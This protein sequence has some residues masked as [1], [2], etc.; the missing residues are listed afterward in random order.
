MNDM[1]QFVC[2]SDSAVRASTPRDAASLEPG[3]FQAVHHPLRLRRRSLAARGGGQWIEESEI[4]RVLEGPLRPDGYLL[5][6]I[7]G[8][9]GTGKSHL[10]R[11]ARD[12]TRDHANW[13]SRYLPKNRTS[14][15]RVIEIVIESLNS[16]AADA[17]RD[18]LLSAPAQSEGDQELADRLMNELALVISA[19]PTTPPTVS[20]P[21]HAQMA[22]KLRRELPDIL[23]DPVVRRRLTRDEAV[24]PR[25]VGLARR[26]RSE[27]DGLDDDA[28]RITNDDLPFQFE[29]IGEASMGARRLLTQLASNP[30]LTSVAVDLINEA[31]PAAVKRVF[32]SGHVDL[33]EIF[34]EVRK[35]LLASGKE[36]VLFIEDLT[37]LH[38]VEREFLDAI[39]E[40]ARS[41]DGDLCS[42]RVLFAVTEGHFDGLDTVRTRCEDA[43]W[44]D[45]AYSPEGVSQAEAASFLGRYL[46]ACRLDPKQ[47][48]D[49]WTDR[50]SHAWLPNACDSC[51]HQV[52]CHETFGRSE[53]GYGLY[54]YNSVAIDRLV[55]SFSSDRFDPRELVRE[56]VHRFLT[57]AASEIERGN[58]PSDTLVASFNENSDPLNPILQSE[59][60]T[61]RPADYSHIV[62]S[63][64]YWSQDIATVEDSILLAFGLDALGPL[65]V[66]PATPTRNRSKSRSSKTSESGPTS[67]P[68]A[69]ELELASQLR[70]PWSGIYE[71]LNSWAGNQRELS[72]RATNQLKAFVHRSVLQNLDFNALP[73]N[74]GA[75]FDEQKRFD[76]DR[77]LRIAGSVT[78]QRYSQPTVVIEQDADTAAALQGL[79]L[80]AEFPDIDDYPR[81]DVYRRHAATYLDEWT[82]CVVRHL[83]QLSESVITEGITGLLA[84]AIVSGACE[85]SSDPR[86]YLAALF[87]ADWSASGV[88]RSP[89][90]Q[91]VL[92]AARSTHHRLRPLLEAHLGEA[93]GTGDVRAV[94]ADQILVHIDKLTKSWRLESTNSAT[95][96]FLRS[97]KPAV[98]E[99]W[100]SMAHLA[101]KSVPYV[102][103]DQ[104]WRQ[105]TERI[106]E[107]VET[108][109][110][111]GRLD[112]HDVARELKTLGSAI[113]E[114]AH[115]RVVR[116]AELVATDP[117]FIVRLQA[118]ASDLPDIVK[119]TGTFVLK[120]E[121]A[122]S[123][124]A[125]DLAARR[126]GAL[127]DETLE[128]VS[129]AVL[130][131]TDRL[132]EAVEELQQ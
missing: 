18:A 70:S 21:K 8:G 1:R 68:S 66:A 25:L 15:R 3:H 87:S 24:V 108:A 110:R 130:A 60:R 127:G 121:R 125:K 91:A 101:T 112:D 13:E 47:V 93:R 33:T 85:T 92:E 2:W 129:S 17:A 34:R 27:G 51:D 82:G 128:D 96:Q 5:V 64:R 114:S 35:E 106:L 42:L 115:N 71:E 28:I 80:L 67:Q 29:E 63:I 83:E 23:H 76:R 104:P 89:S 22:D 50:R 73:V 88:T 90:W 102:D 9:S 100:E 78:D 116:A 61:K 19:E 119:A 62:N 113:D 111:L 81:A 10:V 6:P 59:I 38:G 14:I 40:P 11:W 75:A 103:P 132:I 118:V 26:G 74:L 69:E 77:H 86:D 126:T 41:D 32:V 65:D 7:V 109:H 72:A 30:D 4:V 117:P 97:L 43:Y 79:I 123:G 99:E 124:I 55:T 52:H 107:V 54:P 46:N 16:P 37:V 49:L 105:Q 31:L 131:A 57:V 122:L 39:I 53:E 58:F 44:L 48:E 20:D 56:L 36:L 45:A 95:D 12:R 98:Q 94:R 84:C 120:A